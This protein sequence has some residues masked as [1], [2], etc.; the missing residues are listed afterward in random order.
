ML[1]VARAAGGMGGNMW[2]IIF[3]IVV[4]GVHVLVSYLFGQIA[5][6]KGHDVTKYT[7][8]CVFL[9]LFGYL[10]VIALPDRGK[11]E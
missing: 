3:Y 7:L 2:M 6:M 4:I 11:K 1:L 10:M 9:G 5:K 8:I